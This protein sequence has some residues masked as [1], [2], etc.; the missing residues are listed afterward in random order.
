M[1]RFLF[2]MKEAFKHHSELK[3]I[4]EHAICRPYNLH[5]DEL[6]QES[7]E[8]IV[9]DFDGVLASHG[10]LIPNDQMTSLLQQSCELFEN[11][12]Y[13]LSNKPSSQREH[14][15]KE[16]FPSVQFIRA[17]KKKPYPDGLNEIIKLSGLESKHICLVDDRLLT[18]SLAA[19][20]S[21]TRVI[22]CN[23]PFVCYRKR[24]MVECFFQLLRKFERLF[25]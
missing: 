19:I 25:F 21:G 1:T 12:V 20:L 13:I 3:T 16:H 8:A 22:Y 6:K 4:H 23:K 18:G 17:P 11:Q 14:Y 24:F 2:A 7:V 9:W 5:L 15:F 10:E